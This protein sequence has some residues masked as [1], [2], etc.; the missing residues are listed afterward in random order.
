MTM[1]NEVSRTQDLSA[2]MLSSA[3]FAHCSVSAGDLAEAGKSLL[4]F[5]GA[6]WH[7]QRCVVD[8]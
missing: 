2:A 4:V 8:V 6:A 1:P 7:K 3:L 5:L